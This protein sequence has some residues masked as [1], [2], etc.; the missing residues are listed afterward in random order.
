MFYVLPSI[1]YYLTQHLSLS[2]TLT[3]FEPIF[4]FGALVDAI[5]YM[6]YQPDI[7]KII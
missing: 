6:Y 4:H 1:G 7:K 2:T 3:I 5:I